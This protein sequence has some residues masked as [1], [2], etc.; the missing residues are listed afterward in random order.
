M[1]LSGEIMGLSD[2]LTSLAFL[3]VLPVSFGTSSAVI[4]NVFF[5]TKRIMDKHKYA[6]GLLPMAEQS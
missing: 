3:Y 2:T 4:Q 5:F 6:H 1:R